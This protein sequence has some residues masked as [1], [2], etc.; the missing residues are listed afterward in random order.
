M[1]KP[2]TGTHIR[3]IQMIKRTSGTGPM[4]GEE[5]V[6]CSSY[7]GMCRPT[8]SRFWDSGLERGIIFKPFSRTGCILFHFVLFIYLFF[9]GKFPKFQNIIGD[10]SSRTGDQKI[11]YFLERGITCK[12]FIQWSLH[13]E[14]WASPTQ[15]KAPRVPTQGPTV[16]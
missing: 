5:V 7:T 6:L 13:L 11:A 16:L 15:P 9:C 10:F 1:K 8:G 2:I 14:A 4:P 3:R 12:P